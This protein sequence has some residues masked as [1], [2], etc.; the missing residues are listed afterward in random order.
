M[1]QVLLASNE[2]IDGACT[3]VKASMSGADAATGLAVLN[4]TNAKLTSM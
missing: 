4:K 3:L 2:S 1:K